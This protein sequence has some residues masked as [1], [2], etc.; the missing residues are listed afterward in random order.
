MLKKVSMIQRVASNETE[1]AVVPLI[2]TVFVT[3]VATVNADDYLYSV[4]RT[5]P[6]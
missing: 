1:N 4:P 6:L 5:V 3:Q 2:A